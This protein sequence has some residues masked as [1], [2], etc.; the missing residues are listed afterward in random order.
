VRIMVP[1]FM[2]AGDRIVVNTEELIYLKRA[3]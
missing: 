3:D 1:P 2:E